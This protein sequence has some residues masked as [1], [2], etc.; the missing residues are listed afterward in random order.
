LGITLKELHKINEAKESY[1]KAI[2]INPKNA[3][4]YN[5]LGVI[6]QESGN[7]DHALQFFYKAIESNVNYSNA[8]LNLSM[9]FIRNNNI[10]D[11]LKIL[12]QLVNEESG[13]VRLIASI[14]L[15]VLSFIAFDIKLSEKLIN[16]SKEILFINNKFLKNDVAYFILINNLISWWVNN[17]YNL[18]I[19]AKKLL[20]VIGESHAMPSNGLYVDNVY[21][22]FLCK[23][24]WIPGC[25]QWHLGNAN[26]N[27]YKEQFEK[28]FLSIPSESTILLSIGEIDCRIDDGLLKHIKKYPSTNLS[29]LIESTIENYLTYVYN[30]TIINSNNVVIQGVPCPNIDPL[31]VGSYDLSILINLIN[32]FNY[33]LRVKSKKFG[34]E[35]LDLHTLTDRGDGYSNGIWHIDE[36]HLSPAGMI[37]AWKRH[38]A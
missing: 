34:F 7:L 26:R 27:Q 32:Q 29:A 20:Y 4:A 12:L 13:H 17:K 38:L 21:G 11:S 18:F 35:F 24:N 25:K 1:K 5:N 2:S 36:Y 28:V 3:Q 8:K 30:V 33:E 6:L 15:A 16:K 23:V 31:S 9:L 37:E 10:E 22:G 19:E 14:K